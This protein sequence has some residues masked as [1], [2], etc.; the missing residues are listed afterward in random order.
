MLQSHSHEFPYKCRRR[1]K[2]SHAGKEEKTGVDVYEGM[3]RG[4]LTSFKIVDGVFA[5]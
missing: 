1:F 2:G 4:D 5:V 3:S